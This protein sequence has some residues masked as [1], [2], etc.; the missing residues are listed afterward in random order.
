MIRFECCNLIHI[1]ASFSLAPS[2]TESLNFIKITVI[3]NKLCT[4]NVNMT[5][6]NG[7]LQIP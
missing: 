7:N 2:L 4:Y 5:K 1:L 3:S 6:I